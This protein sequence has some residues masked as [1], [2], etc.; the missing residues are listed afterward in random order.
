MEAMAERVVDALRMGVFQHEGMPLF[1]RFLP[2]FCIELDEFVD[3][4]G[5]GDM[6]VGKVVF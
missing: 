1:A 4:L 5:F 2:F 6:V 3:V